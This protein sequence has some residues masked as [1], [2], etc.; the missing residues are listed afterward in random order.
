MDTKE[1]RARSEVELEKEILD[2]S[3]TRFELR[4]QKS[5]GQLTKTSEIKRIK[6]EIARAKTILAEK[7]R[8]SKQ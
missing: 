2:L 5:A 1:L 4:M 8:E 7:K 3:R 6:I